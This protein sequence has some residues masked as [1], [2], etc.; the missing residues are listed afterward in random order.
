VVKL[1]LTIGQGYKNENMSEE[2]K[3]E[4]I[5]RHRKALGKE[6]QSMEEEPEE[7]PSTTLESLKKWLY[8]TLLMA[9]VWAIY[10]IFGMMNSN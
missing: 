2:S 6:E 1:N 3:E 7:R 8:L 5:A 9:F 4:F 10:Q